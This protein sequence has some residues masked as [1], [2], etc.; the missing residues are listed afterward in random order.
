MCASWKY[1]ALL[2]A[3]RQSWQDGNQFHGKFSKRPDMEAV[4]NHLIRERT[5]EQLG[6]KKFSTCIEAGVLPVREIRHRLILL[7]L[8]CAVRI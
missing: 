4:L 5:K 6:N 8:I 2:S 1:C 3:I 7:M